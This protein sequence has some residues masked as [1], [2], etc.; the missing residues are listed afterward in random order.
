MQGLRS[1]SMRC[2]L[3]SIVST[4][5]EVCHTLDPLTFY[6]LANGWDVAF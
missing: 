4:Y 2:T 5:M 3:T 6:R 1:T